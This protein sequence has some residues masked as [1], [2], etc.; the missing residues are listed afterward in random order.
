MCLGNFEG[1][2]NWGLLGDDDDDNIYLRPAGS[3]G[4]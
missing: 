1:F 4:S 3:A 2:V